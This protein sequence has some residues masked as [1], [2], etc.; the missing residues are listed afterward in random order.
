MKYRKNLIL[1]ISTCMLFSF[2]GIKTH[3]LSKTA[4]V[5]NFTELQTAAAD[6]SISKIVLMQDINVGK[7]IIINGVKTIKGSERVALK[8]TDKIAMIKLEKNVGQLTLSNIYFDGNEISSQGIDVGENSY[9]KDMNIKIKDC[10]FEDFKGSALRFSNKSEINKADVDIIDSKF[11]SIEDTVDKK[12]GSSGIVNINALESDLYVENTLFE[13]NKSTMGSAGIAVSND[14]NSENKSSLG[15][16]DIKDSIFKSNSTS[17]GPTGV[18]G[19]IVTGNCNVELTDVFI[20]NNIAVENGGA[21]FARSS[22]LKEKAKISL[23]T[24]NK[25]RNI[26]SNNEVKEHYSARGGAIALFGNIDLEAYDTDFISNKSDID[27]GAIGLAVPTR[28]KEIRVSKL[29]NVR[30]IENESGDYGGAIRVHGNQELEMK[31]VEFLSNKSGT[32]G[33]MAYYGSWIDSNSQEMHPDGSKIYG[34]NVIFKNNKADLSAGAVNIQNQGKVRVDFEDSLFENNQSESM[35][36]A[37]LLFTSLNRM[38]DSTKTDLVSNFNNTKF[39]NNKSKFGG[40]IYSSISSYENKNKQKLEINTKNSLFEKNKSKDSYGAIGISQGV[41]LNTDDNTRF[42]ENEAGAY[43]G[44]IGLFSKEE[45]NISKTNFIKN[46]SKEMGGS[47]YISGENNLNLKNTNFDSNSSD[48]GGAIAHWLNSTDPDNLRVGKLDGDEVTFK[49]NTANS[50]G[51]AIY[52]SN[53]GKISMTLKNSSFDNNNSNNGGGVFLYSYL[54]DKDKKTKTDAQYNFV[55][56]NFIA[57]E[58]DTAGA[59]RSLVAAENKDDQKLDID[60]KDCL[61]NNNISKGT[62]GSVLLGEGTRYD[63][64]G[65]EFVGNTSEKCG[66]AIGVFTDKEINISDTKFEN[67]TTKDGKGGAINVLRGD[68]ESTSDNDCSKYRN[69]KVDNVSFVD[70]KSSQ[71]IF[72]LEKDI[73]PELNNIYKENF[74]NIKSLS[75]PAVLGKN[76]AYNNYDVSF[77]SDEEI[78]EPPG[79]GGGSGGSGGG[80]TDDTKTTAILANGKKYTDVLTATVL[81]NEKNCP[82]LLTDTNNVSKETMDELKRRGIGEIIISGGENSVSK[83][84][85][86][87][88]NDFDIVRYSGHNRYETARE[89]AKQ[90]RLESGNKNEAVLVDGT[91]FP[92]VITISALASQKRAPILLTEPKKLNPTTENI[93]KEW[94]IEDITIGGQ[95]KSV[96]KNVENRIE[97]ILE[98][99]PKKIVRIGGQDRYKTASLIGEEVRKITGNKKDMILVDGTNF[100]DGITVNSLA[101]KF[102]CPIHLT[103]PNTLTKTTKNDISSWKIE[104][105]LVAGGNKS[106]SDKIYKNL[107]VKN[108]ERVAGDNRYMTA[109]E[110][111]K[112]FD[113]IKTL[114]GR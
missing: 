112:R 6:E 20:D 7:S 102:E 86:N 23:K 11:I 58:A 110:I 30:F 55:K 78:K 98:G 59:I 14:T 97:E 46:K 108:K 9:G 13:G 1:A 8:A 64:E 111:S 57:N 103:N 81:A 26:I 2:S 22:G 96:S 44:A 95:T 66:G 15:N 18:G 25:E 77:L 45:A 94:K 41:S 85:A 27:G 42:V 19:A 12:D 38:K 87:Q 10:D 48:S 47:I 29:N 31:D 70:N 28:D 99:K 92:D 39:I 62:C 105:I 37:V 49:N 100:P 5:T 74:T 35:G 24:L 80:S 91:N 82:I 43:G 106:V 36:G 50:Y 72:K 17:G 65:G 76:I 114:I 21:I 16:V 34:D 75:K 56:T 104:N 60:M 71:G 51:G 53:S 90:V 32:G 4:E 68:T 3:A 52:T 107:G 101:S 73:C 88:L 79:G 83:N 113:R 109:V 93:I 61:V 69:L 33:A 63:V 84:V 40:A 54:A 89:I 67:N